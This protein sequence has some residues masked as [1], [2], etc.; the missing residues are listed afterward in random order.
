MQNNRAAFRDGSRALIRVSDV[1]QPDLLLSSQYCFGAMDL[2]YPTIV[3]A[4]SDVLSWAKACRGTDL[5][6]SPWLE[7]YKALVDSGL[8]GADTVI[9]PTR[10]MLSALR[11]HFQ[12]P[13]QCLVIPNGRSLALEPDSGWR[14]LQAV[15]AGRLWDEAKN[16]RLLQDVQSPMPVLVAG[17][18]VLRTATA[19]GLAGRRSS[20]RRAGS[21]RVAF[22]I[23]SFS[24]LSLYL[25]LRAVW[26]GSA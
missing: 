5:E 25:N 2:P 23:P 6:E 24:H 7:Q 9:A 20:P 26:L 4:H 16:L 13:G 1:F 22:A 10:W 15:T 11:E 18:T 12:I 21:E 19:F 3:V 8:Q 14:T 17:E